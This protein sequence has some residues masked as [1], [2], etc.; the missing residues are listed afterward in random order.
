MGLATIRFDRSW[1]GEEALSPYA[2][3]KDIPD[4]SM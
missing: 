3:G 1:E 4:I 2:E